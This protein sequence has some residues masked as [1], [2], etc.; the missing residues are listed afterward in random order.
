MPDGSRG[1]QEDLDASIR[2]TGRVRAFF[3]KWG[4]RL[5]VGYV[6]GVLGAFVA[7]YLHVPLPWFLGALLFCLVAAVSGAPVQQPRLLSVPVRAVLGVAIGAAFTPALL[8]QFGGMIG[9]LLL[10]V[11]F[12]VLIIGLGTV[13]FSR[14]AGF[15]KPTAFFCAVP[16]GLTDMVTMG[17]DAGANPRVVT[18]IQGTRVLMIVALVPF[19]FQWAGSRSISTL[20]PPGVHLSDF[21]LADALALVAMGWAGWFV[22]RRIGLAGAPLIGPM[23]LSGLAHATGLT[24]AKVPVE[25]LIFAQITL[26]IMLGGQFRGITLKEFW[27]TLVWGIIFGVLLLALT[28]VVAIEISR[29]TGFESSSVLLA[30]APGG[31]AELNL[32]G[33]LLGLDVAFI[34]LHHLVRLAIVIFG[35]QIVFASNKSWRSDS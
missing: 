33:F 4:L 21:G 22:A 3:S 1:S 15:D 29:L 5:V 6:V 13:F 35:A 34:A 25:L 20:L 11:P 31:Q 12:M 27:N 9:S 30:Y 19:W 23:I 18:L 17:T 8:G 32:L 14:Y 24:S 16:G 26:G 10:L 7:L 2:W 28:A